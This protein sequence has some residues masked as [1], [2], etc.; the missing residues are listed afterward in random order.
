MV[1]FG[2]EQMTSTNSCEVTG[3]LIGRNLETTGILCK[4]LETKKAVLWERNAHVCTIDTAWDFTT[5]H[6]WVHITLAL[7]SC[8]LII[9]DTEFS[10]V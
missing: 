8:L 5:R 3:Y 9:L 1:A 7:G 6:N 10:D 2:I 4:A